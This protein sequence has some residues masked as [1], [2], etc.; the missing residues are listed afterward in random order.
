VN[1][2]SDSDRERD[3]QAAICAKRQ[4]EKKKKATHLSEG[5]NPRCFRRERKSMPIT[6][7]GDLAGKKGGAQQDFTGKG[8]ERKR[9]RT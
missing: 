6:T 1:A 3:V 9:G 8:V 7:V 2:T 5:G 4:K